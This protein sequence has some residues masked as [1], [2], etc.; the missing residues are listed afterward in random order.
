MSLFSF[1]PSLGCVIGLSLLAAVPAAA[2]APDS[3]T[4]V[5]PAAPSGGSGTLLKLGT[6]FNVHSTYIGS[7]GSF[8]DT[9]VPLVLG[10]EHHFT[11]TISLYGNA[12]TGVKL[13]RRYRFYDGS[14]ES[15]LGDMGFDVGVRYYYNQEKRRQK[16]RTTGPFAGNYLALQS[17]SVFNPNYFYSYRYSTL[18]AVWGMQRRIGKYG[19][20]DA[21]IGAGIGREPRYNYYNPGSRSGAA[22]YGLAPELGIKF[23]LGGRIKR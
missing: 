5:A 8:N 16:G 17:T 18:T 9:M 22:H 2:Q 12:F 4:P 21:Y 13:G 11:P 15:I 20:F 23:S 7:I 3:T 10:A 19:L 14:R 1:I 6:G